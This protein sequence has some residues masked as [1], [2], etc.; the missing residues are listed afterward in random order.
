MACFHKVG[1]L[2]EIQVLLYISRRY[3]RDIVGSYLRRVEW[4][5]SGQEV[6]LLDLDIE[7]WSSV[8]VK[9]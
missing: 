4:I 8:S 6:E 2:P 9:G 5:S 7:F 1:M 3:F